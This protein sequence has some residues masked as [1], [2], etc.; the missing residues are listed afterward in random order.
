[1][2]HKPAI[3]TNNRSKIVLCHNTLSYLYQH[4]RELILEL[5]NRFDDVV[6]VAPQDSSQS[7]LEELGVRCCSLTLSRS[8]IGPL[9]EMRALSQ[10]ATVFRRE[11]PD[12]VFNFSIKP[13]IYAGLVA[14]LLLQGKAVFSM[15]TGLGY[16]FIG[17][18]PKQRFLRYIT[19][20]L[21]RWS[22]ANSTA[23]FFQNKNDCES[24]VRNKLVALNKTRVLAGTGIDL[25][26]F[27][28]QPRQPFSGKFLF[29]GR[30]LKDKGI[31]ELVEACRTLKK[32]GENITLQLLGP[33]D[34]NPSSFHASQIAAWELEGFCE[35]LGVHQDV[36][37]FIGRAD[38]FVLPSYREGL[39]RATL[40]AMAMGKPVV[41]TD[42]PGCRETVVDGVN[43]FLV[44]ARDVDALA[45]AMTMFFRDP[46]RVDVMGDASL[47]IVKKRFDVK[48]V[49]IDVISEIEKSRD[50]HTAIVSA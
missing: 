40:E 12:V 50:G 45:Y 3:G 17:S 38:V 24:F 13:V 32:H 8:G 15:I 31:A 44:S 2:A 42:V 23:V 20:H 29:I 25:N 14:R 9:N 5:K 19:R 7:A 46:S 37:P 16:V 34:E 1:M 33:V 28:P 39:P 43:G 26:H 30:M 21:Y 18:S 6:C 48:N 47:E 4:Y 11:R 36:R 10:Y 35:Y 22:L 27:R 41:T 49:V